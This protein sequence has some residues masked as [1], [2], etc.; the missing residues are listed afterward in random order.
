MLNSLQKR[1]KKLDISLEFSTKAKKH[2]VSSALD[3][4]E[5]ARKLRRVIRRLIENPLSNKILMGE[6]NNGDEILVDEENGTIIF[7]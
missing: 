6:I 5:G 1:V 2:I 7:I 3:E 4:G